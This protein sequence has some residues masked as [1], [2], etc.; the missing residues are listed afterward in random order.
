MNKRLYLIILIFLVISPVYGIGLTPASKNLN[1]E[2]GRTETL[3]LTIVNNENRAFDAHIHV[4]GPLAP[5]INLSTESVSFEDEEKKK[6][7]Y[8]VNLPDSFERPGIHSS[9]IIVTEEINDDGKDIELRP[10]M[11][12]IHTLL[13]HVPYPDSYAEARITAT[14][15]NKGKPVRITIPIFNLGEKPIN[16]VW[17]EITITNPDGKTVKQIET[18]PRPLESKK[19]GEITL[20]MPVD[21]LDPG[22]Y[23]IKAKVYY[24]EKSLTVQ[25]DFE[26]EQFLLKL[27]SIMADEY[28]EGGIARIKMLIQNIGNSRIEDV[29]SW[30]TIS[31]GSL[32]DPIKG[33]KLELGPKESKETS[34][35]W[36]TSDISLGRYEGQVVLSYGQ[37]TKERNISMNLGKDKLE[38]NLI[39]GKVIS[40]DEPGKTGPPWHYLVIILLIII[41]LLG[42][43]AYGKARNK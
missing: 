29:E 22:K 2:P 28:N 43:K 16:K 19:A 30:I 25:T 26:I 18:E 7:T 4:T 27:L 31:D 21:E 35:Y 13:C 24:D 38:I 8:T 20:E 39:T 37:E 9:D 41:V 10:N 40:E 12:V 11:E 1:F 14:D 5:Y 23:Y 42:L 15:S 3:A 33:Y 36:D 32:V 34:A 17:T 6:F